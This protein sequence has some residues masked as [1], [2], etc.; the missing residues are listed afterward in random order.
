MTGDPRPSIDGI[1]Q[2]RLYLALIEI[3]CPEGFFRCLEIYQRRPIDQGL[4]NLCRSTR[5]IEY[6]ELLFA[7]YV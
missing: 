3:C 7:S 5:K 1:I 2:R 6:Q 4:A